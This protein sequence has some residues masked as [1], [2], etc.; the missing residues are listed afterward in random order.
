MNQH[1]G[2]DSEHISGSNNGCADSISRLT[3][4]SLTSISSLFQHYPALAGYHRYHPAPELISLI[5]IALLNNSQEVPMPL[6]LKG[7]FAPA[8][9]TSSTGAAS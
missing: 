2:L 4:D 1:T 8:N 6:R 3:K 9:S 5:Y 7:H